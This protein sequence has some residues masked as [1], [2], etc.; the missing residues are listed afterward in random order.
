MHAVY[1]MIQNIALEIKTIITTSDILWVQFLFLLV[2]L[3]CG[4]A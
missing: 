1:A 4:S 3:I 2:S